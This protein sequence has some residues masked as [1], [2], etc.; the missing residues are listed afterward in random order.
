MNSFFLL[1]YFDITNQQ[2]LTFD[3]Y[4]KTQRLLGA[5]KQMF[6]SIT[7][8]C[9]ANACFSLCWLAT[10]CRLKNSSMSMAPNI[11][12]SL[13]LLAITQSC[14]SRLR[15]SLCYVMNL[16]ERKDVYWRC[17]EFCWETMKRLEHLKTNI[18]HGEVEFSSSVRGKHSLVACVMYTTHVHNTAH[19]YPSLTF[20][21]PLL[22]DIDL[23]PEIS[24]LFSSTHTL[25]TP[26]LAFYYH[27]A[28]ST[29]E[30]G[31]VA[32]SSLPRFHPGAFE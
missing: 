25:H 3:I 1:H 24:I 31:C 22:P 12:V 23:I 15:T 29:L 21:L 14:G 32:G 18:S 19:L 13:K 5:V 4:R 7:E 20:S 6:V 16:F 2:W 11:F 27:G 10:T 17:L 28:N 30:T 26:C 9:Q 8:M